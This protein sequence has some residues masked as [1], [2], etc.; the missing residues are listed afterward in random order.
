MLFAVLPVGWVGQWHPSPHPQ[1]VVLCAGGGSCETQDGSRVEM[2]PGDVHF[3]QD[4]ETA[5]ADG[6]TVISLGR[7]AMSRAVRC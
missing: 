4:I 1:W 7:S 6:G 3:G 2:G 5:E